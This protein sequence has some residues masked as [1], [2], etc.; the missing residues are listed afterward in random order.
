[1][2]HSTRSF[3]LPPSISR[4]ISEVCKSPYRSFSTFTALPAV[5]RPLN[6]PNNTIYNA[7]SLKEAYAQGAV[8][9]SNPLASNEESTHSSQ[10][11]QRISG[12]AVGRPNVS[13]GL[14]STS[15]E[16]H[17]FNVYAHR[18]NTHI[19]ITRPNRAPLLSLSAGNI[20]FKHSARGS[21]D[22]AYQLA[23]YSMSKMLEKGL[24]QDVKALELVLRGYGA[25]REA[26]VKAILGPEGR[27]FKPLFV[28]VTDATRLKFGGTK[29][30]NVRR[31]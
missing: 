16:P 12:Q 7:R 19:T 5:S 21:Y 1:M 28:R 20:G 17:H 15:S 13:D 3:T 26:V 14:R 25:G 4:H 29:S 31:L 2:A 10:S 18:H 9:R 27:I 6:Q 11:L 23:V 8:K 22:A 30:K 24:M